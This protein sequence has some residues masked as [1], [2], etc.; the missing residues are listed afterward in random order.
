MRSDVANGGEAGQR[1]AAAAIAGW[2]TRCAGAG[3][4]AMAHRY[5]LLARGSCRRRGLP[6]VLLQQLLCG[7]GLLGARPS[8]AQVRG[9][10]RAQPAAPRPVGRKRGGWG[11]REGLGYHGDAR[12]GPSAA[13]DSGA[14]GGARLPGVGGSSLLSAAF[15]G[16]SSPPS[17]EA[18]SVPA[19]GRE[20]RWVGVSAA[21]PGPAAAATP[22]HCGRRRACPD[23]GE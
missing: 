9:R 6:G 15:P 4:G 18:R 19:A 8:L 17:A 3:A 16:E 23:R 1:S 11:R 13:R 20:G 14:G 2:R 21:R 12:G 5:L 10:A 7:R 22:G